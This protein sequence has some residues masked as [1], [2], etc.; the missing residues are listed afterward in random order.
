MVVRCAEFNDC[1]KETAFVVAMKAVFGFD[2][3]KPD[4]NG[5]GV[6]AATACPL[7][8]GSMIDG[9]VKDDELTKT[10]TACP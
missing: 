5:H 9:I 1:G 10:R 7:Y 6:D 4:A 8:A 3:A 2:V